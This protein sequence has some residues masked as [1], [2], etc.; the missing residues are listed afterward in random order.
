MKCRRWRFLTCNST[1]WKS[2]MHQW[3][4]LRAER[5]GDLPDAVLLQ[6]H[7]LSLS[8]IDDAVVAAKAVSLKSLFTPA[9]QGQGLHTKAGVGVLLR[10][11]LGAQVLPG[12]A[13]PELLGRV[14]AARV[15]ALVAGGIT[16]VSFYGT[17]NASQEYRL[18]QLEALIRL[19]LAPP[20][21][22]STIHH[23]LGAGR[24]GGAGGLARVPPHITSHGSGAVLKGNIHRRQGLGGSL[25]A[26]IP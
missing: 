3:E 15:Y 24:F 2:W 9:L 1:C 7:H 20:G 13:E 23:P 22:S 4:A 14:A 16:L 5:D 8:A 26:E 6:E 18:Q 21:T 19:P 25:Q 11:W 17:S 12:A 10:P